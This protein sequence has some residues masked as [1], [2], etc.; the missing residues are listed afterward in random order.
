MTATGEKPSDVLVQPYNTNNAA[1]NEHQ[2]VFFW[3]PEVTAD[4]DGVNVSATVDLFLQK[5]TDAGVTLGGVRVVNGPFLDAHDIMVAHYGVISAIS[6]NGVSAITEAAKAKLAEVN[7]DGAEV[8]GGHQFLAAVP[9]FNPLSLNIVNDNLGTTRLAGGT[10]AMK[11][12]VGGKK[13]LVLNPFHAYQLVPYTAPGHGLIIAEGR[14]TRSWKDLRDNVCGATNPEKANAGSI[15]NTLLQK[16]DE[17]GLKVVDQ[18]T[19]GCHMSA[20]PLEAMVELRRFFGPDKDFANT[21]FGKQLLAA[22]ATEASLAK[23]AANEN[24]QAEGKSVSAFDATEEVNAVDA[25]NT[26]KA[27]L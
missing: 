8:L 27:N 11:I 1:D 12:K 23:F 9:A 21:S 16:R 22:G 10:Y 6:K 3:K 2:F 14:S 25:V 13:Y 7:V 18:G 17:L 5:L 4:Y 24:V 26:L 20:G 19:N 15:R